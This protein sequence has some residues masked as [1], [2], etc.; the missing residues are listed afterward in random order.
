[1]KK[2]DII[3]LVCIITVSIILIVSMFVFAKDGKTAVIKQDNTV[4]GEYSLQAN[5]EIVLEQNTVTIKDG[6]VFISYADCPD[7]VCFK[8]SPIS[9]RGE[10]IICLPN[11]VIVEIR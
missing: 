6:K 9:K 8:H 7:K 3:T 10:T 5:N 4:C 2:G 11:K 1:M